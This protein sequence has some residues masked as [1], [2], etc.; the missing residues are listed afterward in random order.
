MAILGVSFADST[1][2]LLSG[3][4]KLVNPLYSGNSHN[5]KYHNSLQVKN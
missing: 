4:K 2:K 1:G 3:M 5:W